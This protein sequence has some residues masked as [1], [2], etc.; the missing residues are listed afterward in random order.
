M[1]SN[2]EGNQPFGHSSPDRG[3]VP[4]PPSPPP[5]YY[6]AYPPQQ[7]GAGYP[8]YPGPVAPSTNGFAI[9]SLILSIGGFILLGLIG[10]VLGVIFGH[11]ARSQIRQASTTE[12]G[13]G[14]AN[15]GIIIG[16]I[17]LAWN[18]V[19]LG[20]VFLVI[21]ILPLIAAS[22]AGSS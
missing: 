16:Y 6:P 10:S 22:N 21:F 17:G 15:A 19:L 20:I 4:Y 18:V 11:V 8:Y 7:F 12:E 2:S 9:A 5:P 1:D 13:L 3:Q 14:L